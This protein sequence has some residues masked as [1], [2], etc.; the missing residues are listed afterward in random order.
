[1]KTVAAKEAKNAF[2]ALL[3]DAQRA[4]VVVEK[5]GRPVVVVVSKHDFDEMQTA[6]D[7]YR[8]L[9]E[10]EYLLSSKKNRARLKAAL[11]DAR[12]GN[13]IEKN[14]EELMADED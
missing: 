4:P 13:V 12:Q 1:M 3:D 11:K 9:K 6:L 10:T 5:K 14:I 8:S 7:D 2:G